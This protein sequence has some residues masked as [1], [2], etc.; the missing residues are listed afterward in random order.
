MIKELS[1]LLPAGAS[2]EMVITPLEDDQ[3]A[4]SVR[5]KSKDSKTGPISFSGTADELDKNLVPSLESFKDKIEKRFTVIAE[6][7]EKSLAEKPAASKS[8][9]KKEEAKVAEKPKTA[10]KSAEPD[11]ETTLDALY[12]QMEAEKTESGLMKIQSELTALLKKNPKNVRIANMLQSVKEK[13][14]DFEE[15]APLEPGNDE[16]EN[17]DEASGPEPEEEAKNDDDEFDPFG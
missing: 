4:V 2:M 3:V 13:I 10:A 6:E 9:P 8:A 11:I 5:I 1:K 12:D 14:L 17:L 15:P 7:F 16:P